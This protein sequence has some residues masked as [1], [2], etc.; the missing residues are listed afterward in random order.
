MSRRGARNSKDEFWATLEKLADRKMRA[1]NRINA[2][3]LHSPPSYQIVFTNTCQLLSFASASV[4]FARKFSRVAQRPVDNSSRPPTP[5]PGHFRPILQHKLPGIDGF[6]S[7]RCSSA[8]PARPRGLPLQHGAGPCTPQPF[9]A[10][11]RAR[12]PT[13]ILRPIR[14]QIVS[15]ETPKR[16]SSGPHACTGWGARKLG[17]PSTTFSVQLTLIRTLTSGGSRRSCN[18]GGTN[19]SASVKGYMPSNLL[20]VSGWT[21]PAVDTCRPLHKRFR[22][23]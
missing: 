2:S 1:K 5:H 9:Q 21:K 19:I 6:G 8:V 16:N 10:D 12:Q 4:H 23:F 15:K 13:G 20:V 14:R 22:L 11:A 18:C 3:T 7:F 17:C